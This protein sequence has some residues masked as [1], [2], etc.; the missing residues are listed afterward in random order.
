MTRYETRFQ[1]T[2]TWRGPRKSRFHRRSTS[3]FRR[4]FL[5]HATGLLLVNYFHSKDYAKFAT[6]RNP[7]LHKMFDNTYLA[8]RCSINTILSRGA[9]GS[10]KIEQRVWTNFED[11][12]FVQK[13][14]YNFRANQEQ[15]GCL[16][17]SNSISRSYSFPCFLRTCS[18]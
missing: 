17:Y 13:I 3:V 4:V 10:L 5:N 12:N 6:S 2:S 14:I 15:L 18:S 8:T 16:S 11:G 7:L 9:W 1:M